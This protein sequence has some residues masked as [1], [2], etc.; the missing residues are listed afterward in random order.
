VSAE[1]VALIV[2]LLIIG[3]LA[4]V[5]GSTWMQLRDESE[6]ARGRRRGGR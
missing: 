6:A 2:L 1:L 5:L 3:W 4:M